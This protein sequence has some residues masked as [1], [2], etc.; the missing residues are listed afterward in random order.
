MGLFDTVKKIVAG[1]VAHD[2]ADS[3]NPLKVGGKAHTSAPTAVANGDR[4]NAYF[5]ANGRLVTSL[6]SRRQSTPVALSD[7]EAGDINITPRRAIMTSLDKGTLSDLTWTATNLNDGLRY[8]TDLSFRSTI[9]GYV[10]NSSNVAVTLYLGYYW[11]LN[12]PYACIDSWT[13]DVGQFFIFGPGAAGSGAAATYRSIPALAL[14][15]DTS[16]VWIAKAA[17]ASS[18][19]L[20]LRMRV[21]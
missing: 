4:V 20:L 6:A 10:V 17:G 1:D 8:D 19:S 14:W 16:I 15:P 13:I 2:A 11:M 5:D 12:A 3:G 9:C 18:G 21:A 7:G